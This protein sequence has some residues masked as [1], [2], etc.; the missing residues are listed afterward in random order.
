VA[1]RAADFYKG[2]IHSAAN[3][4][5]RSRYS[6]GRKSKLAPAQLTSSSASAW[7]GYRFRPRKRQ[8]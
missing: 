4:D 5:L 6:T 7:R 2:A 1:A 8:A 3:F